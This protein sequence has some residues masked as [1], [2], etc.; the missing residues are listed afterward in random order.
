[1]LAGAKKFPQEKRFV[2]TA[3]SIAGR[4]KQFAEALKL[5]EP[6]AARWPEDEKVRVLLASAHY[7]RGTDFLD[8]G[9]PHAAAASLREAVRLMPGDVDA[10]MNLGRA[11][12]NLQSYGEALRAFDKVTQLQPEFPLVWFHRGMSYYAM[13]ELEKAIQDLDR[14][15]RVTPDYPPANL[16]RGLARLA[17]GDLK[18]AIEDLG[19]SAG[20]MRDDATAQLGY[21]RALLQAGDLA[22]AESKLRRAMQLDASD[23]APVNLLVTVLTRMDRGEEAK[24]LAATAAAL[25]RQN[26]TAEPG[27]IRFETAGRPAK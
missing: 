20:R 23:P 15:I 2:L 24:A 1:V 10:Q 14:Q 6:A 12:H 13:G 18:E 9:N 22:Q 16:V 27:E 19:I 3:A 7:G 5:L 21:G 17:K 26:R 25:A 4:N 11:L 8:G